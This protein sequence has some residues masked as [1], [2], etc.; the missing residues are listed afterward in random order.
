MSKAAYDDVDNSSDA[1]L[2]H[3]NCIRVS[4]FAENVRVMNIILRVVVA[5]IVSQRAAETM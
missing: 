1:N 2:I 4:V 3:N 5:I